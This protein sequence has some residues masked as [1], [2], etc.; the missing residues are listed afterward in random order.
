[1]INVIFIM[2]A[3]FPDNLAEYAINIIFVAVVGN[4]IANELHKER[5]SK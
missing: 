2:P 1:M 3:Y 4:E 5:E